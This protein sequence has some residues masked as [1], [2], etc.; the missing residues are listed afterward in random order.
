[1]L[2]RYGVPEPYEKLKDFTRGRAVT[3]DSMQDFVA[4]LDGIPQAA[5]QSLQQL[6]PATYVGNAGQQA[7]DVRKH[8]QKL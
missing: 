7:M 3:R 4:S 8:L 6:T 2:V 5:K 1:M